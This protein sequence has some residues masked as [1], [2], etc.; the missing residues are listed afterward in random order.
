MFAMGVLL[1]GHRATAG[2]VKACVRAAEASQE[3]RDH[4]SY[5]RA[6]QELVTCSNEGCPQ[7][8]RTDCTTWL[9]EL[10]RTTPSVIV[11]A[12]GPKSE[13]LVEVAV[14]LDGT[15]LVPRLDGKAILVDPGAHTFRFE[16][17][18]HPAVEQKVLVNVG[19]KLRILDVAFAKTADKPASPPESPAGPPTVAWVL[20]GVAVVAIGTSAVFGITGLSKRSDLYSDPCSD[21]NTCSQSDVDSV[22]TRFLVADV[23]GGIGI[24]SAVVAGYFFITAPKAASVGVN[25]LPGG[26]AIRWGGTF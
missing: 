26:G 7:Q 23:A 1:V 10:D 4:G 24:V 3:L 22:K 17:A 18:G 15:Q 21:T 25:I 16:T 6:R 2:D 11:H 12:K 13:D 19:E 9:N 5:L 20:G 8:I 14:S